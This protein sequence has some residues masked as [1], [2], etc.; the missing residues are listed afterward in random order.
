MKQNNTR[1]LSANGLHKTGYISIDLLKDFEHEI[2]SSYDPHEIVVPAGG[3]HESDLDH[4]YIDT[5][6]TFPRTVDTIFQIFKGINSS[7]PV[8]NDSR[9]DGIFRINNDIIHISSIVHTNQPFIGLHKKS[10]DLLKVVHKLRRELDVVEYGWEHG[11]VAYE[12]VGGRVRD[13]QPGYKRN[14]KNKLIVLSSRCNTMKI[15][16]P[17]QKEEKIAWEFFSTD[18]HDLLLSIFPPEHA[19][20][21]CLGD[22]LFFKDHQRLSLTFNRPYYMYNK[23]Y[24]HM[25]T[26][27]LN[28]GSSVFVPRVVHITPSSLYFH[29]IKELIKLY[30][31]DSKFHSSM[32]LAVDAERE[33]KQS[34]LAYNNFG[35][36]LLSVATLAS[37][38]I[39]AIVTMK[40]ARTREMAVVAV[41]AIV[42]FLFFIVISYILFVFLKYDDYSVEQSIF[43]GTEHKYGSILIQAEHR[44]CDVLVG[45]NSQLPTL[46]IV[47]EVFAVFAAMVVL[48]NLV[49][50]LWKRSKRVSLDDEKDTADSKFC[51]RLRNMCNCP[52]VTGK[53]SKRNTSEKMSGELAR[54]TQFRR[55]SSKKGRHRC[56]RSN[57]SSQQSRTESGRRGND[58]ML[59]SNDVI[60]GP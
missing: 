14:E 36:L 30:N 34:L 21:L 37:S 58:S 41:E 42:I 29:E 20:P 38:T 13:I 26:E 35:F 7:E 8:L 33:F 23:L 15:K 55:Y 45:K 46:L 18:K 32:K 19:A 27:D 17:D 50:L 9:N 54:R 6:L 51:F 39:I 12:W 40:G 43:Q 1:A 56:A 53:S 4:D 25:G 57:F 2:M 24:K 44:R 5:S 48:G 47:T 31:E 49:R 52:T 28:P 60:I 22:S 59:Q 16:Y 3:D 11:S 10:S